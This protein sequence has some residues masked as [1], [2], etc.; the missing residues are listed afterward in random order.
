MG[1]V[2]PNC[3]AQNKDN[4]KFCISCG[5]NIPNDQQPSSQ[6]PRPVN[7][8][9]APQYQANGLGNNDDE[10]FFKT[11]KFCIVFAFIFPFIGIPYMWAVAKMDNKKKGVVTAAAVFLLIFFI[12]IKGCSNTN[13]NADNKPA[14][15]T[16]QQAKQEK[17]Q[18]K[19]P[20]K[21]LKT[22]ANEYVAR[23]NEIAKAGNEN[24]SAFI[25]DITYQEKGFDSYSGN[26]KKVKVQGIV[27][28]GKIKS[29]MVYSTETMP[30]EEETALY[31]INSSVI[32]IRAF[33]AG[34]SHEE[35]VNIIK[36]LAYI[37]TGKRPS[38]NKIEER[39]VVRGVKYEVHVNND[40]G[41]CLFIEK[42]KKESL[43]HKL[44]K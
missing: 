24:S 33:D 30:Q 4:S 7:Q 19:E 5:A 9:P 18:K 42:E 3:G 32:A 28:N 8:S 31:W 13:K 35:A 2:C 6:P 11:N 20:V 38:G 23:F 44:T 1:K 26:H 16:E 37:N 10:L 29:L 36:E 34:I 39:T 14:T 25:K 17:E 21:D 22:V 43:L 12:G 15:Q 41:F 40:E 27:E